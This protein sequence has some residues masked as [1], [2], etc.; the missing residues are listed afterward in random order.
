[1]IN[2]RSRPVK[3]L[4]VEDNPG[5]AAL[6]TQMLKRSTLVDAEITHAERVA[7]AR[8]AL[9]KDPFDCVLLDLGLPDARGMEAL[10]L[11]QSAASET[12]VLVLTG[13]DDEGVGVEALQ[14]GAQ[15]FLTKDK[16]DTEVLGRAILYS[17]ERQRTESAKRYFLDNAA[18]ELR[19]PMSIISGAAEVLSLHKDEVDPQ[20]FEELIGLIAKHGKRVG[21]LLNQL[22]EF[23]KLDHAVTQ[24]LETVDIEAAVNQAL[25]VAPPP[26]GKKVDRMLEE[27]LT[28]TAH[29]AR[30]THV[31]AHFLNN[32]YRYGGKTISIAA[33]ASDGRIVMSVTDDGP[34][35]PKEL[36]PQL[37]EPFGRGSLWR[38]AGS[39]LGLALSHRMARSFDGDVDYKPRAPHGARFEVTLRASPGDRSHTN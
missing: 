20:R 24:E 10:K 15:D 11:V 21:Q 35:V 37:F 14:E 31:L 18:H 7:T 34:G 12:A 29:P 6:V 4:L 3:V 27:G 9:H 22:L 19:T 26:D 23:T 1:M 30:L 13:L 32:A 16:I 8:A 39:G 38:P 17:V 36:I 5:D 25:D 33:E 28:A 2:F